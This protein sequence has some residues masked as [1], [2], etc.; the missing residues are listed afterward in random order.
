[1]E[2]MTIPIPTGLADATTLTKKH[3]GNNYVVANGTAA[4]DNE[5]WQPHQPSDNQKY[6]NIKETRA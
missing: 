5:A 4:V 2:S 3:P 6:Q 1:M